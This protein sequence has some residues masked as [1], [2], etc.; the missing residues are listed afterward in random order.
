MEQPFISLPNFIVHCKQLGFECNLSCRDGVHHVLTQA[1]EKDEK[2]EKKLKR[3]PK[4]LL[5]T[6]SS[7]PV[8]RHLINKKLTHCSNMCAVV[9][10]RRSLPQSH[11][12]LSILEKKETHKQETCKIPRRQMYFN[13]GSPAAVPLYFSRQ[14]PHTN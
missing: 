1:H 6:A 2:K 11:V 13:G 14:R 4:G 12:I 9:S 3:W 7:P 8:Q 5:F 10:Y